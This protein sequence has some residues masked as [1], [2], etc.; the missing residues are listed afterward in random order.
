[1]ELSLYLD[2]NHCNKVYDVLLPTFGIQTKPFIQIIQSIAAVDKELK[3]N[4]LHQCL[5]KLKAMDPNFSLEID[6]FD[7][8]HDYNDSL[9]KEKNKLIHILKKHQKIDHVKKAIRIFRQE[10]EKN[11]K[12]LLDLYEVKIERERLDKFMR[13]LSLPSSY[14]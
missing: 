3:K 7:P 6:F 2:Q 1:M 13:Q 11:C 10:N 14:L 12:K 8:I 9:E 4:H 5:T